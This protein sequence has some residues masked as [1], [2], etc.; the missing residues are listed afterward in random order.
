LIVLKPHFLVPS[1]IPHSVLTV[2]G[3][4]RLTVTVNVVVSPK[5]FVIEFAETRVSVGAVV[6][7]VGSN[8]DEAQSQSEN[9][10]TPQNLT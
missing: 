10:P 4:V 8:E 9:T 2:S 1:P 6:K 5:N 7:C 3:I